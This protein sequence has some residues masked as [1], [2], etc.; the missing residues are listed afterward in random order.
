[1]ADG[2]AADAARSVGGIVGLLVIAWLLSMN[3]KAI[4]PRVVFAALGMQVAI[5]ALILF[6]PIG[7]TVLGA[8]VGGRF[9]AGRLHVVAAATLSN[10]MSATIAGL[11]IGFG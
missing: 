7:N 9:G 1:M 8:V 10:L 3:R 11:F 6:V 5:G 4:R 2:S